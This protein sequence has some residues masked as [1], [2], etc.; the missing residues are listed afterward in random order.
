VKTEAKRHDR[1]NDADLLALLGLIDADLRRSEAL[2]E[3]VA[4]E[5][6]P[7]SEMLWWRNITRLA[8][9]FWLGDNDAAIKELMFLAKAPG[10]P[11]YGQLKL[12]PAWDVFVGY[13]V[14]RS[15]R[16]LSP[17]PRAGKRYKPAPTH[18]VR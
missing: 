18:L 11:D 7:I 1:L 5:L 10:G 3:D 2:A 9:I 12:D 4:V 17:V 13:A 6:R 8:M 15:S 14:R 16:V